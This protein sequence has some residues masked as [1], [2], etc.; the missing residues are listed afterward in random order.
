[1]TKLRP[2]CGSGGDAFCPDEGTALLMTLNAVQAQNG[3]AHGHLHAR[4]YSCAV[5]SYFD[6]NPKLAYPAA[7]TD[8]VAAVNDSVPNATPLQRK[9][10]VMRWLRWRLGK[11]GMPGFIAAAKKEV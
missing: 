8:V 5:G 7:L 6:Q 2:E 9:R 1:M 3:L 10:L 4:G 11:L